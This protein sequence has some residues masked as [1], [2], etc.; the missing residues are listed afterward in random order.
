MHELL[1]L[2]LSEKN[3]DVCFL[4]PEEMIKDIRD[5]CQRKKLK[6]A[7]FLRSAL[8]EKLGSENP[9]EFFPAAFNYE[10][11]SPVVRY[12]VMINSNLNEY[13]IQTMKAE[14]LKFQ[15]YARLCIS[16]KIAKLN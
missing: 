3:S 5:V 2:A 4:L 8:I 10:G 6:I 15:T 13:I 1:F 16:E 14:K 9:F 7:S 11:F 12:S